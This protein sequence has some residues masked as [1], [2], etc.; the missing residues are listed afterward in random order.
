MVFARE[1]ADYVVVGAGSTGSVVARRLLEAGRSVHVI[2]AGLA[3]IDPAIHSLQGWP[4]LFGGPQDWGV[5]TTPQQHANNRRLFWP[6]GKVLGGSSSL[7]GM[8]YIRGHA[9][10]YER[11]AQAT[12]DPSWGWDRVLPLFKRSE[13]HELGGDEYHGASGPLP[14][15]P[16]SDPHPLSEAFIEAALDLGHKWIDDFNAEE[17][18]GVGYNHITAFRGRR[19]SAWK[20]FVAPM[21]AH[22]RLTVTTGALVHRVLLEKG[23]A[24]GVTYSQ[25]AQPLRRAYAL[26]E[27]ILSAGVLGSPKL[28]LLSGIGPSAHL[29]SVGI[30]TMVD[31]PAVGEN[32]HDHLLVSNIYEA[33]EPLTVGTNNL[34]EAQLYARSTGWHGAAP[35][36]QPLFIHIPYAAGGGP[37]PEH[38]YTIAAGLVAPK[39]RGTLRLA[40]ADPSDPPL[41]DP[42][43]LADNT[44]LEAMVDAVEICRDIGASATFMPWRKAEVAPGPAATTRNALRAFV[45]QAVGTYH[46]QVGTCKMGA[47][48]D[49]DAVVGPDLRVRGVDRLRVADASI[50]P[51]ITTGN[52]NA[53]SIMIGEHAAD[54][55]LGGDSFARRV[56]R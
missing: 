15:T 20:S 37:A 49:P 4:T 23:R 53:P 33:K 14:V 40:S 29:Q 24:V 10:D 13:A 45:R 54:L 36:L 44:D 11:W 38:G 22:P 55:L 48:D 19:M 43:V 16:I 31:L 1:V 17:M 21:Q 47:A 7:N 26:A 27:V 28:L 2:E 12:G 52:T 42:N 34:L 25:E 51:T 5:F 9:S 32:L 46:H 30:P 41:A 6:R 8:I 39:A 56:E 35:N 50:M 3:D 18:V